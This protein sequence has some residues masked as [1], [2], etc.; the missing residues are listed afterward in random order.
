MRGGHRG[1]RMRPN[2]GK[3]GCVHKG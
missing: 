1:T 2:V 3:V